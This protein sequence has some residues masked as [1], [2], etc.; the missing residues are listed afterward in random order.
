MITSPTPV[1]KDLVLIGGGHSHL[2]VLK[3][4]GMKPV[5]GLRLTLITRDIH[6]PYSGMLPGFIAGR[7]NY[8]EVHVDLRPLALFAGAR[9]LHASAQWLDLD[10]RLVHCDGRPPIPFDLLSI[11][12]GSRPNVADV[13]GAA[14]FAIAVKPIDRFL[15]RWNQLAKQA[16][17]AA[18]HFRIAVVGGGAAGVELALATQY[19]LQQALR[20]L[21]RDSNHLEFHLFTEDDTILPTHNHKVQQHMH[22]RMTERG[23]TLHTGRRVEAVTED[24]VILAGG[25]VAP[26]DAVLW[27]TRASAPAWPGLSGLAVDDGGF[28]QVRDTLES[29]SHPGVFAAGDIAAMVAHPRPKSGVFAV[30]QGPPLA[31]NLR[32]AALGKPLKNYKPQKAFLSLLATGDGEAVAS[33]GPLFAQGRKIWQIKDWID[34]RFMRNFSALPDMAVDEKPPVSAG[35]ADESA[36]KEISSLAMRCGGCGAKVGET[37]LSNVMHRLHPVQREDVLVGLDAPDDAAVIQTPPN[38][39]LVQSVDYFRAFIDDP[40][41]FGK[42]AAIHCLGDLYAMGASPQSA[43]AIA[44]LPYGLEKQV[45]ETLFQLMSGALEALNE[46]EAALAG[47]HT[48]EGAELGFGLTVNGLIATGELLTKAGLQPGDQL[49]LTKPLGTGTLLA[50]DMRRQAKGRWI[51]AALEQ[52]QQSARAAADVLRQHA[53]TACTDVT[54]FG[55]LGHLL[56]MAQASGVDARLELDA[57]P[58][59]AGADE[60]LAAGIFSTMQDQNIRLRR[61]LEAT[62]A[63][64]Q[65][66]NFP[67]LFDP[68]TAGGLLAGI[69]KNQLTACLAALRDA[70]YQHTTVIGEATAMTRDTDTLAPVSVIELS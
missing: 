1:V 32:R 70:G 18:D 17:Q 16:L 35:L 54:G 38:R 39:L 33:R 46:A 8:D 28:I 69:P 9:V 25:Q 63:Q 21:H 11:N 26:I 5:P 15:L 34:R 13:D 29:V 44:T 50:A 49:V 57:M 48:S 68:Q 40:Y 67:L 56:E 64:R 3:S 37:V 60:T 47:G 23:I 22:Q 53:V 59:M 41:L 27:A 31:E 62:D 20:D 58:V 14:E 45:E 42:I 2:A 7:Y 36:L 52:M 51:D 19:R 4:F 30:R 66:P 61:A 65:H 10:N 24:A 55:L 12:I 43:L 6:T